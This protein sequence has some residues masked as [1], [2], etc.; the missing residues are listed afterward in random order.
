MGNRNLTISKSSIGQF[1]IYAVIIGF[2]I[3]AY[4]K[5][6]FSYIIAR[7]IQG[8]QVLLLCYLL[9]PYARNHKI[10]MPKYDLL[11]HVWWI[12]WLAITVFRRSEVWPTT[13]FM[14][15][16]A[17]IFLLI[18]QRYW[19]SEPQQSFK[20]LAIV[21]SIYVYLN[22]FLL[23]L[24]PEGLWEYTEWIGTGDETRYLFGNYNAIGIVCLCALMVQSIYSF[25]SN[26]G[27]AN[28]CILS[29]VS[30]FTVIFVGSATSTI[31]LMIA[32]LFILFHKYIKHPFVFVGIFFCMYIL[33]VVF[34][35][36]M[37]NTVENYPVI[38]QFVENVLGKNATFSHRTTIW[39]TT[40]D[41]ISQH[42]WI[43]NG[44][45]SIE[46]N[47]S[48]IG[49]SGPH[50]FWLEIMMYGGVV[51]IIAFLLLIV[52]NFYSVYRNTS[53]ASTTAGV[54]LCVLL[55]MSLFETYSLIL[56]FMILQIT[57]DISHYTST[58][59]ISSC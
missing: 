41:L 13:I 30:L 58:N 14:W 1:I 25:L 55:L 54:F 59:A 48:H 17:T 15:M 45:Q 50:N 42:L 27:Y 40:V 31:G 6:E 3:I 46:W 10:Q 21:L 37:G 29:I 57:Y 23:V 39:K 24:Y 34:I 11:V 51:S 18:G 36:F 32:I 53:Y 56:I 12:V 28:L 7:L 16:N 35:V 43:G 47:V 52:V 26:K 4:P 8:F 2:T 9:L 44:Y 5:S 33:F 38:L 22:A 49:A 20:I 19:R